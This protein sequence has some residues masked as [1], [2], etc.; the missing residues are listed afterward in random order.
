MT[1]RHGIKKQN[2]KQKQPQKKNKKTKK[3][4]QNKTKRKQ[5]KKTKQKQQQQNDVNDLII[6][7]F[8]AYHPHPNCQLY[9]GFFFACNDKMS[10]FFC[11]CVRCHSDYA[12][13]KRAPF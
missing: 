6:C 1:K 9:V 11:C 7:F 5:N 8:S 10:G 4:K 3:T 2:K 13:E 12:A